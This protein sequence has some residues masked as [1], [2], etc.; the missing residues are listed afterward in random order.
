MR[1]ILDIR[2]HIFHMSKGSEAQAV[3][4]MRIWFKWLRFAV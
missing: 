2:F 4:E 1:F 3:K